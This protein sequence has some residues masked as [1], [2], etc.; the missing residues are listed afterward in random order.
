M[1]K[2]EKKKMKQRLLLFPTQKEKYEY[3]GL[4]NLEAHWQTEQEFIKNLNEVLKE[5]ITL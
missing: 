3:I 2:D 4:H 1:M 5:I